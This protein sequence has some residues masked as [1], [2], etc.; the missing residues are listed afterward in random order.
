MTDSSSTQPATIDEIAVVALA[1]AF[2]GD[3]EILCNPIGTVPMCAGRLARATFEPDM[4]YTDGVAMLAHG[5]LPV[6]DADAERI[7]EAYMPYRS[8]FDVV[9]S[10]RRHVVMGASQMDMYGNQNF[11]A[12]GD[13][14]SKPKVQLLGMRGAP[15][16]LINNKTSYWLPNH[17]TRVFV[18]SVDVV[19]GP[20]YDRMREVGEVGS[21]FHNIVRVVT[22][23][24]AMDFETPDNR[25]RLRSLHPGVTVDEVVENTGF[26][27][28]IPDDVPESRLPTDEELQILRN[29]L[30][31]KGLRKAE[32]ASK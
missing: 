6:G 15:G 29:E 27:L 22:P 7:P 25:M 1:E 13:D 4:V 5:N 32:F 8:L 19:S 11:A 14:Y 12:I 18:P 24:A 28:V 16:N 17:S 9:W 26:D 3:G 23:L 30:D 10:G 20:G 21:R 31:P 2:R